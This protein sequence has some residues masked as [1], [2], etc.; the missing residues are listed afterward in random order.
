MK[1]NSTVGVAEPKTRSQTQSRPKSTSRPKIASRSKT[2]SSSKTASRSKTASLPVTAPVPKIP[3]VPTS[4]AG[5]V[6]QM[7]PGIYED[8]LPFNQVTYLA[9]KMMLKPNH[10]DSRKSLFAFSDVVKEAAKETGVKFATKEARKEPLQIRE[11]L[12]VDT[13]DFRLYNNAFILRRRIPYEDG[14]PVGDP[15]IV[16]KYRHPDIQSAAETDVRPQIFGAHRVK[17]KCQALPLKERLGGI[18]LLF[19]HNVQ[20]P[21][22]AMG[23]G[24]GED[25]LM[26]DNWIKVFPALTKLR[27]HTGEKIELVSNTII[28]EVLQD[29]GKLDF[30]E[31]VTAKCDVGIWRTRG[32]HRPLIGEFAFQIRFKDRK[33]LALEA[34]QRAEAFFIALQYA[35]KDYIALKATKT[36]VVYQLLGN[37]PNSHE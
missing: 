19:S 6:P 1:T 23:T 32:E 4:W 29:I 8:G 27:K 28:E 7:K 31:G 22:S 9:C 36:G 21:R 35:A 26:F 17:F 18:R 30:G 14:F 34:M 33:E 20:F 11:V 24:L 2:A 5:R 25:M 12:F 37:A 16:F 15:E 3:P 13:H 10:F